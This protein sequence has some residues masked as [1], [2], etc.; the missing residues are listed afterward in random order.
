MMRFS[1]KKRSQTKHIRNLGIKTNKHGDNGDFSQDLDFKH[2][3]W[4]LNPSE[5]PHQKLAL[6][7]PT[8]ADFLREKRILEQQK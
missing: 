5:I 7:Q 2:Q 8:H 6:N 3:K 1:S 4:A